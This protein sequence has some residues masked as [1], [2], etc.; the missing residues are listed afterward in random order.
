MSELKNCRRGRTGGAAFGIEAALGDEPVELVECHDTRAGQRQKTRDILDDLL[1]GFADLPEAPSQPVAFA[2]LDRADVGLADVHQ[3]MVIGRQEHECSGDILC[4]SSN[5]AIDSVQALDEQIEIF[6]GDHLVADDRLLIL[7]REL[8]QARQI[9][10]EPFELGLLIRAHP[11]QPVLDGHDGAL[12]E[13]AGVENAHEEEIA[14]ALDDLLTQPAHQVRFSA[15]G[16]A[17]KDHA[18]RAGHG[19]VSGGIE[20]RAESVGSRRMHLGDVERNRSPD[21]LTGVNGGEGLQAF[22]C[23]PFGDHRHAPMRN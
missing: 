18:D 4:F 2:I 19:R 14:I 13:V 20:S 1:R 7:S 9:T 11:G 23:I 12:P 15:S 17:L 10:K 6:T 5:P 16:T 3:G 8:H 21:I 22:Q